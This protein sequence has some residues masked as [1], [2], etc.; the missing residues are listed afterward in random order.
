[1]AAAALLLQEKGSSERKSKRRLPPV[2]SEHDLS[3]TAAAAGDVINA[4]NHV[5]K[6]ST[7]Q[8]D[9]E[10]LRK[11]L[12]QKQLEGQQARAGSPKSS[13][14][15]VEKTKPTPS[16][17]PVTAVKPALKTVAA[18]QEPAKVVPAQTKASIA[19]PPKARPPPPAVAPKPPPK[20]KPRAEPHKVETV[21][22]RGV[23]VPLDVRAMKR[24]IKEELQIVTATRRLKI[25][26]ME[27]IRIM[28]RELADRE[29]RRKMALEAQARSKAKQRAQEEQERERVRR[30]E[31]E[32]RR[33]RQ[34]EQQLESERLEA[35]Q[36]LVARSQPPLA[37]ATAVAINTAA[38]AQIQGDT[39]SPGLIGSSSQ[40]QKP[41]H[42]RQNSDPLLS[43][44]SPIEERDLESDLN[45][46]LGMEAR[47]LGSS[48]S[49]TYS[50]QPK[51]R[52]R[53]SNAEFGSYTNSM[54]QQNAL[55]STGRSKSSEILYLVDKDERANAPYRDVI[56]QPL[57]RS[58][59]SKSQYSGI[60]Q[61]QNKDEKRHLLQVEIDKRKAA[62][63]E[64]ARL[65]REIQKLTEAA[66]IGEFEFAVAKSK[67][68]EH[69]ASQGRGG[70][71]G[72]GDG[73]IIRPLDNE[74]MKPQQLYGRSE[75]YLDRLDS[76]KQHPHSLAARS[77]LP[78]NYSST[79]Y[80]S[81]RSTPPTYQ[82]VLHRGDA[83]FP[84]TS[85]DYAMAAMFA[86]EQQQQA[87]YMQ[88]LS[89][90]SLLTMYNH[91]LMT[92]SPAYMRHKDVEPEQYR[93]SNV[94]T[95][96]DTQSNT[97]IN[98]DTTVASVKDNTPSMPILD[99]VTMRS[100]SKLRQ[101]GSRPLSDDFGEFNIGQGKSAKR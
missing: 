37:A 17:K 82:E 14:S 3:A 52:M 68:E 31:E 43:K 2:P 59:K 9:K 11:H 80:L 94:S 64:N 65:R 40:V 46:R 93:Y 32:I 18:K 60:D 29:K 78:H 35:E 23:E 54:M 26:E 70:G 71:G 49:M 81:H 15:P 85:R 27:E 58:H 25:D 21:S 99:D 86:H 12:K 67:Y 42:K 36:R 89:N 48:L 53:P 100:R 4:A 75:Q 95:A 45:Y 33:Q 92:S 83:Y 88:A 61:L 74:Q 10:L 28:E 19:S 6:A 69:M 39:L 76:S 22:V 30:L 1:M 7:L 51:R 41:K 8:Q 66:N 47:R 87:D 24:R 84:P 90:A 50:P 38:S 5:S 16:P 63:A 79:E 72:G 13:Y 98:T 91:D 56:N 101:I 97:S 44:F 57:S 77:F 34:Q 62:L 73:R 55:R 20:P 96:I